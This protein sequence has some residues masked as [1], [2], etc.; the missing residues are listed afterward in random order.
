MGGA[1]RLFMAGDA[2]RVRQV[3][4]RL[5]ALR[6]VA[7]AGP[8][9]AYPPNA[10]RRVVARTGDQETLTDAVGIHQAV[11]KVVLR[12]VGGPKQKPNT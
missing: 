11:E 9:A 5:Q 8:L 2:G 10:Q 6:A 12:L 1:Y 7:K 3:G 4:D